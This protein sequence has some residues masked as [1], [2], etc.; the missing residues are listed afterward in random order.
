LQVNGASNDPEPHDAVPAVLAAFDRHSLVALGEAHRNQNVH[1]F[2]ISL[3]RSQ[4][5][6]NRVNDIV[7]EFGSARYQG[8]MD[9]F[10]DGADVSLRELR[11]A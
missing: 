3:I 6:P 7:V 9:R 5:F 10:I 8:I 1:D 4:D 2:A 11:R